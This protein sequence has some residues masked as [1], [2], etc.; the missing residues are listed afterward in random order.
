MRGSAPTGHA[1]IFS[2]LV[3]GHLGF[4]VQQAAWHAGVR[5]RRLAERPPRSVAVGR[6]DGRRRSAPGGSESMSHA[7]GDSLICSARS[8]SS[9]MY[10]LRLLREPVGVVELVSVGEPDDLGQRR[11]PRPANL[12]VA[13]CPPRDATDRDGERD[14][15]GHD[16][17]APRRPRPRDRGRWSGR[18]PRMTRSG[19]IAHL[20]CRD[21]APLAVPHER[22]VDDVLQLRGDI[23]P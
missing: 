4:P 6:T 20:G 19:E 3:A 17:R 13:L 12:R 14:D 1:D 15:R 7:S 9:E 11:M 23:G 10:A 21:R 18:Q 16:T 5:D 22:P 8:G 2:R